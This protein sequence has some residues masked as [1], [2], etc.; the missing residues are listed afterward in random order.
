MISL[1]VDILISE[2]VC[3]I[4][5]S[6]LLKKYNDFVGPAQAKHSSN[7]LVLDLKKELLERCTSQG[8]SYD[9]TIKH[10]VWKRDGKAIRGLFLDLSLLKKSS[11]NS[12]LHDYESVVADKKNRDK[13]VASLIEFSKTNPR[14]YDKLVKE[15]LF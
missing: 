14:D 3:L 13:F 7:K 6:E 5:S 10:H 8:I 1:F 2:N 9:E 12:E 4:S 11:G 15:V